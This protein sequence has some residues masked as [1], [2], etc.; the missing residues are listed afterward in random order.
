[1]NNYTCGN[2]IGS[3]HKWGIGNDIREI[4]L[5]DETLSG[6]VGTNI[7]PVIAPEGTLGDFILY[8]R[9][10]YSKTSTKMGIVEDVCEVVVTVVSDDYDSSFS[11]AAQV[12]NILVGKHTLNSGIN[13][14]I[15]L[16]D[17]TEMFEDNK[18]IQTMLF[19]IK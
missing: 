19:E 4:L 11:I 12:D 5:A 2:K 1:M 6:V 15:N 3:Y 7:F 8:R 9:D 13:V 18:Y 10:K 16:V 14:T 17:S